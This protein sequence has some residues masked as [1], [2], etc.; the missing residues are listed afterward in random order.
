MNEKKIPYKMSYENITDNNIYNL[1]LKEI[2]DK[3]NETIN[4][5]KSKFSEVYK[6]FKDEMLKK[7]DLK[8]KKISKLNMKIDK[9]E[10]EIRENKF[11]SN[12]NHDKDKKE[13]ELVIFKQEEIIENLMKSKEELNVIILNKDKEI[14]ILRLKLKEEEIKNKKYRIIDNNNYTVQNEKLSTLLLD[15]GLKARLTNIMEDNEHLN[16]DN[17]NENSII[18]K[19]GEVEYFR[20]LNKNLV[21]QIKGLLL[22]F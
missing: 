20:N 22:N 1:K 7:I 17:I 2:E 16:K 13:F 14:N 9:L 5:I 19:V 15:K 10:N 8:D 12:E 4:Q 3:N 21:D 11:T 6:K 18:N